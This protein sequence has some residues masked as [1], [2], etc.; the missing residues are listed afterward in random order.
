MDW[1]QIFFLLIRLCYFL[2][3]VSA[4]STCSISPTSTN[5]SLGRATLIHINF[6]I[7]QYFFLY[8]M[9]NSNVFI[10]L[11][12]KLTRLKSKRLRSYQLK[13]DLPELIKNKRIFKIFKNYFEMQWYSWLHIKFNSNIFIKSIHVQGK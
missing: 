4:T 7:N 1:R 8:F 11:I 9:R 5:P 12:L 6:Y 10:F 3:I 2:L 13:N